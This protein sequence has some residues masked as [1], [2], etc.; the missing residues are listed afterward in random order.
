[1][2]MLTIEKDKSIYIANKPVDMRKSID[3]LCYLVVEELRMNPQ[4]NCLYIFYNKSKDKLKILCWHKNGF[5]LFYKRL[6]RG[7]F[8]L[9]K[10]N[11]DELII[12]ESQLQWLIAGLDFMLMDE[13]KSLNYTSFF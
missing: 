7:R 13:F 1:M 11:M 8:K 3:G 4:G 9:P 12:S 2:N 10:D 5:I 6:E